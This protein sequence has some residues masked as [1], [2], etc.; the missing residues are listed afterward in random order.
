MVP[1]HP[2]EVPTP[3]VT[4]VSLNYF[5]FAVPHQQLPPESE[6]RL[7]GNALI[8]GAADRVLVSVLFLSGFCLKQREGFTNFPSS[9]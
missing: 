7:S 6:A 8:H 4:D 9:M 1:R 3:W 2:Q 5:L